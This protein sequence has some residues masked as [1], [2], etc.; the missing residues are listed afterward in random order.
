MLPTT[1]SCFGECT[2]HLENILDIP[3]RP[4]LLRMTTLVEHLFRVPVAYMALVDH[5]TQVVTRIGSGSEYWSLLKTYPLSA[6]IETPAVV[7]DAALGLPDGTSFGD[8]RFAASAP[9]LTSSGVSLGVLVIADREPRP[10]FAEK[11]T[12]ALSE[13]ARM[14]A[15]KMELRMIAS[16]ALEAESALRETERRFRAIANTAPVKIIYGGVDGSCA[17]VNKTWLNFTGRSLE[18]ELGDGWADCIHPDYREIAYEK[19]W[20][21]FEAREAFTVE[22]PMRRHDGVYRWML[23]RRVPRFLD[24]G[25]FTGFVGTLVDITDYH[26]AILAVQKQALCTS[27]VAHAAGLFYPVLDPQGKIEQMN[28]IC[29]RTSGRDP[30]QMLGLF[31]WEACTAAHQGAVAIRDAIERAASS[32][33]VVRLRTTG[34]SLEG[35]PMEFSWIITPIVSTPGELIAL[36]ATVSEANRFVRSTEEVIR[37]AC[38]QLATAAI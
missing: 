29:Q 28:P 17:F 2:S 12:R 30:Q 15:G 7:Q 23:G 3:E 33:T 27:A 19:Y 34:G 21:A 36:V 16:H 14:L 22:Y 4:D 32:R 20:R 25:T 5:A 13:L 35:E 26:N 31:I 6:V 24:D 1:V 11:D 8:L 18:E 38:G 10:H 37:C 9:L